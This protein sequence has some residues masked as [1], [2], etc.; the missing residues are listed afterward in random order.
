MRAS[1][2]PCLD[3][4]GGAVESHMS[5]SVLSKDMLLLLP[6]L[7]LLSCL[8]NRE[9]K[10][11]QLFHNRAGPTGGL[12]IQTRPPRLFSRL[13]SPRPT[14]GSHTQHS[15]HTLVLLPP[16]SSGH[17]LPAPGRQ[18]A[19]REGPHC[20]AVA[21]ALEARCLGLQMPQFHKQQKSERR[22]S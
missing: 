11:P 1:H 4:E 20:C 5:C 21:L 15:H 8:R 2:S 7:L 9:P 14:L 16:R 3:D 17:T 13:P 6:W 12:G 22:P 18:T 19:K 10:S